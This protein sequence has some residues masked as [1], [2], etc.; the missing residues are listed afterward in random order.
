MSRHEF[1][2]RTNRITL[3]RLFVAVSA[4]TYGASAT[5]LPTV[6][7]DNGL[8]LQSQLT[9]NYTVSTRTSSADSEYLNDPN[10][11]DGTR[12]F[13]KW[14]LVNNRVSVFGEVIA[15]Y[16]NHGA[17]LRASHFYD[18]VYHH[19]NKNDSP[20]TV[21]TSGH[22]RKFTSKTKE[23]SGGEAR[24]LDAYVFSN[25][26]IGDSKY[27]SVKAGRHLLAWGE[28]LF[29][30]NI[31]QGQAPVDATKFN[32]PGTEAKDA[33]LPAGQLSFNLSL[34]EKI[35]LTGFWQYKWEEN[36]LNPV[37]DFFGSDFFG[38]GSEYLRFA[39]GDLSAATALSYGGTQKPGDSGQW[40]L[41]VRY[42][43][44]FNTEIGLYHYRYH[45]RNPSLF[46][47]GAQYSSAPGL[48]A[49]AGTY[50]FKYLEDIKLT[51]LSLST[52]I[53]DSVQIGADLSLRDG[54][55]VTLDNDAVTTGKIVQTNLNAVYM[56]GPS[57]LANQT[58]FM[59]E[60][61]NERIHSVDTL[62]ITDGGPMDGVFSRYRSATQT[63]SS[64]LV[65]VAAIMEYPS[66]FQGWDLETSA[67]WM[68]NVD[69]SGAAG[70]GRDEKRLTVG[71][72]FI[73][74]QNFTMGATWVNFLSSANVKYG[75]LMADRDHLAVNF[76]YTF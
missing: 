73:Y 57:F 33:Y 53:A 11:D 24:L 21:N 54:A 51:G 66:V 26:T 65:G 74:K 59:G 69:G 52:K 31:S 45:D 28:S 16:E 10:M 61:M 49:G 55:G 70:F 47:G 42:S 35:A 13:D 29:W 12:N 41:G 43:P 7:F 71:G 25:F 18:D 14:G 39:S 72:D 27:M 6:Q 60:V 32:V 75:R 38:P 17:V 68:Q 50:K 20:D 67:T 44:D 56:I 37:G 30:P 58:T 2:R 15:R 4:I 3:N 46:I 48:N 63:K 36:L 8:S 1:K 40:G 9:T 5:A 34:N 76:K 22:H 62:R 64:T 19:K 23:R